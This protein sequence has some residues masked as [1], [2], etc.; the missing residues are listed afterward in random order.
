MNLYTYHCETREARGKFYHRGWSL[1]V[2]IY[3][4]LNIFFDLLRQEDEDYVPIF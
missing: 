1:I 2:I 4:I 3:N